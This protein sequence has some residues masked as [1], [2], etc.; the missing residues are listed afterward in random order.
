MARDPQHQT[1]V[2][3][4]LQ[5]STGLCAHETNTLSKHFYS[6]SHSVELFVGIQIFL[7][8]FQKYAEGHCSEHKTFCQ[9]GFWS[10][11]VWFILR[12]VVYYFL[13]S[14]VCLLTLRNNIPFNTPALSFVSVL[15]V[16][17]ENKSM[18][19]SKGENVARV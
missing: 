18:L 3:M 2:Y 19:R 11:I 10:C 7:P 5:I 1:P 17:Q 4:E 14:L 13:I 15:T 8:S 9:L 16:R 12:H 6:P